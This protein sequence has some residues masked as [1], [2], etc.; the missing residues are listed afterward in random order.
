MK[1]EKIKQKRTKKLR[2]AYTRYAGFWRGCKNV[3]EI[4]FSYTYNTEYCFSI[5]YFFDSGLWTLTAMRSHGGVIEGESNTFTVPE[6]ISEE[7]I[8]KAFNYLLDNL[9]PYIKSPELFNKFT[10]ET[11]VFKNEWILPV[12][13]EIKDIFLERE[14]GYCKKVSNHIIK[15]FNKKENQKLCKVNIQQV[16]DFSKQFKQWKRKTKELNELLEENQKLDRQIKLNKN[17]ID[18]IN[19]VYLAGSVGIFSKTMEDV[20]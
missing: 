3:M 16:I 19:R 5:K 7:Q 18:T 13:N 9:F 12:I 4:A 1:E 10:I 6:G 2:I 11:Y 14:F 15:E 8:E 17:K 20:I